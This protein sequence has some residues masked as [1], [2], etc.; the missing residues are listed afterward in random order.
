M[1]CS[2]WYSTAADQLWFMS[3]GIDTCIE[4]QSHV[5]EEA[6]EIAGSSAAPNSG[7]PQLARINYQQQVK[8][9][10]QL[11]SADSTI[12]NMYSWLCATFVCMTF[13]VE[14][15]F[16]LQRCCLVRS[17]NC[18]LDPIA[19]FGR[20]RDVRCWAA[21]VCSCHRCSMAASSTSTASCSTRCRRGVS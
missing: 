3:L 9:S 17:L 12:G 19:M 13:V 11:S 20:V 10:A 21:C 14:L 18:C 15:E 1:D 8:Y 16:E 4:Y 5:S 7:A 6:F 2:G